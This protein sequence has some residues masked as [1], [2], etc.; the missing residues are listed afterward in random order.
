MLH[1]KPGTVLS[2]RTSHRLTKRKE[3]ERGKKKAG[4]TPIASKVIKPPNPVNSHLYTSSAAATPEINGKRESFL[5]LN[6]VQRS[7]ISPNPVH[8][9]SA[10]NMYSHSAHTLS[11]HD[12]IWLPKYISALERLAWAFLFSL[13]CD[14]P[15]SFCP[16]EVSVRA[17]DSRQF[18][19]IFQLGLARSLAPSSRL[20][21][22]GPVPPVS[23]HV[24]KS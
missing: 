13:S 23:P 9:H 24:T 1:S 5:I 22:A 15:G 20:H 6:Y 18:R 4:K 16:W 17:V 7:R 14:L 11:L 10:F 21:I 19:T 3:L 8:T 2:I 12:R